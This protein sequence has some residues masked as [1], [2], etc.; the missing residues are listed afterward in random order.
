MAAPT[1]STSEPAAFLGARTGRVAKGYA[2]DLVVL[3]ANPLHDIHNTQKLSG[4][5][6]RGEYLDVAARPAVLSEV[7]RVAAETPAE[8]VAAGCPCSA[9]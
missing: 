2:A 3:D 4:A 5:V 6:V 7:E 9:G 1:A 8:G